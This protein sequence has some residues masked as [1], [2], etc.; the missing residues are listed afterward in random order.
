[1]RFGSVAVVVIVI[2]NA[3]RL[4]ARTATSLGA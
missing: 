1:M 2:A 4:M 3:S